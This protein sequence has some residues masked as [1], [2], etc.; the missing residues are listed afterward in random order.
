MQQGVIPHLDS[1]N[2]VNLIGENDD[3]EEMDGDD[4]GLDDEEP[5]DEEPDDDPDSLV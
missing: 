3:D 4:L 2:R 5:V 1:E